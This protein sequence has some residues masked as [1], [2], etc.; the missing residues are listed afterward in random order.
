MCFVSGP[1]SWLFNGAQDNEAFSS[2]STCEGEVASD[3]DDGGFEVRYVQF[4][5]ENQNLTFK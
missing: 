4:L 1:Y 3:E 5:I 2:S